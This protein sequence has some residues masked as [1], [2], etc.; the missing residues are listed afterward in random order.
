MPGYLVET[1]KGKGT[2]NHKNKL[3]NGKIMV[4]LVDDK[5]NKTGKRLLCDPKKLKV[6]GMW[7]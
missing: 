1:S 3:V 6:I 7:D 5:F 4:D 2:T